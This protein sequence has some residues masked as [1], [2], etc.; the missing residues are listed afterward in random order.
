[1]N[2]L[3]VGTLRSST[4]G[5]FALVA[6]LALP[7][8]ASAAAVDGRFQAPDVDYGALAPLFAATG[9]ALAVLVV[10]LLMG[11]FVRQVVVPTLTAAGALAVLV[12]TV[13]GW[14]P[15]RA[16][17]TLA[18]TLVVDVPTLAVAL[19]AAVATLVA[20]ALA[21]AGGR[22]AS[23]RAWRSAGPAEW[24]ALLL[25]S[26]AG[27]ILLAGSTS[28]VTLFVGV[29]LLSIPLYVLCASD[30]RRRSSLEAGLKYLIVGSVAS[31][32]LLFGLAL[33]Y[34]ATGATTFDA[35]AGAIG[36]RVTTS[37][38]LLLTGLGL[39]LVG[40]AFKA[41]V[42]PFH[43]WTPDVY[44]GAP[45]AV[46]AFMAV[47]TKAAALVAL[48]RLLGTALPSLDD[49]WTP[50]LATLAVVTTVIGNVGA[51]GQRSLKRLLAWSGIGQ[52]GYML[53]AVAAGGRSGVEA[54]VFYLAAYALMNLAAFA[55]VAYREERGGLGDDIETLRG[56]GRE[57]P[58]V[59]WAMT[60]S[61]LALAG[62]PGT[63]GFLG[64]FTL[65]DAAVEG[66]VTW[67]GIVI[68][69]GSMI[70]LG[71][72]LRVVAAI[73]MVREA[74]NPTVG[75]A[76]S[77]AAVA[78]AAGGS[79]EAD[80]AGRQLAAMLAVALAAAVVAAFAW[81]DPLFDIARDAGSALVLPR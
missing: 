24:S 78:P 39:A 8:S 42:A 20:V 47:A 79:P 76:G 70:S 49:V 32:T 16:R 31:A 27:M 15:G 38:A 9:G 61:M 33:I 30:L 58:A 62:F 10:G 56:L 68:V 26:V 28:L 5:A 73:W 19:V 53:V 46:T 41:S 80:S 57:R 45:T 71:Y 35:I 14:Q 48:V 43:Q 51:L 59:A 18:G 4:A 63:V 1:V 69:V 25:V 23:G 2:A 7:A 52:A 11:K 74:T 75:T 3:P 22:V 65:I 13:A 40:L 81:P 50:A 12:A 34:G 54:L 77:P 17:A 29:E 37:D 64:K 67:L 36:S 44:Q 72:Y 55:V 66:G 60:L 21:V 6:S